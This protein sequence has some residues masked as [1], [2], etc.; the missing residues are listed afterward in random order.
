MRRAT[1]PTHRFEL[2]FSY[3]KYVSKVL[4]S[5]GQGDEI[6]LEKTESD[7]VVKDDRLMCVTLTQE[8]TN[9]FSDTLPVKMQVRVLT[10]GGNV[11]ASRQ[12]LRIVGE[13][14]NDEVLK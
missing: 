1:T 11:V 2:P 13:V 10:L 12:I 14:L 9:K 6:V 3:S 4:I 7:V 8:E 5:Y